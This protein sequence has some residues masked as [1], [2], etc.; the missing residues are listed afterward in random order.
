LGLDS[1]YLSQEHLSLDERDHVNFD[2][3]DAFDCGLL[4]DHIDTLCRG[5]TIQV[6]VYDFSLHL[7]LPDTID[8]PWAP[9]VIIEGILALYWEELRQRYDYSVYIDAPESVRLERRIARDVQQRGRTRESVIDQWKSSVQATSLEFCVPTRQYADL[10]LDGEA[11]DDSHFRQ[12]L[13]RC[14]DTRG[15]RVL[16][17]GGLNTCR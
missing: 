3:P 10:V 7:R 14:T 2:H 17:A 6:P 16:S 9:V 1:Y 5:R 8:V 11:I 4:I 12:I 13:S 15:C